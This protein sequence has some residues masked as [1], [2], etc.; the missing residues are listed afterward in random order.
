MQKSA[1]FWIALALIIGFLL[2]KGFTSFSIIGDTNNDGSISFQELTAYGGMWVNGQVT[3]DQLI[4]VGAS[5][6]NGAGVVQEVDFRA[7]TN[8]FTSTGAEIAFTTSCGNTL[9]KAGGQETLNRNGYTNRP[10]SNYMP[11]QNYGTKIMDLPSTFSVALPYRDTFNTNVGLWRGSNNYRYCVCAENA[12][13]TYSQYTCF[14]T[15]LAANTV[16]DSA[17]SIDSSKEKLC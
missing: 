6:V 4:L 11:S 16:S 8:A 12:A 9:T 2:M 1:Y 17:S 14:A 5:W 13:H 7:T 3:L 15:D 10:C